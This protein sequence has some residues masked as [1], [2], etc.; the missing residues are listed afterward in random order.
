MSEQFYRDIAALQKAGVVCLEHDGYDVNTWA[1]AQLAPRAGENILRLG[2]ESHEQVVSLVRTVGQQGYVLSI[3]RSFRALNALSVRSQES[4]LEKYVRFLYL[5]LDD[6]QGHLPPEDFDRAI[7]G[8][9]LYYVRRPQIVLQAIRQA[10]KPGGT[11]FFYGPARKD[12]AELRLFIA[13]LRNDTRESRELLY[14]EQVGMPCV[15]DA[16]A[17]VEFARFEYPLRFS[18]PDALYTHWRSSELYEE[19]LDKDFRRAAAQHFQ[20]HAVFETAQRL[21]GIKATNG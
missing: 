14:M 6:L 21:I 1:L 9:A 11:F 4:R 12:L 17:R 19:A 3:D 5:N 15:R 10:L 20:S 2:C 8:R 16:F 13:A 18:S 7:S